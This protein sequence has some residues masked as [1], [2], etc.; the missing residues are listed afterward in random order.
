MNSYYT[1]ISNIDLSGK[2]PENINNIIGLSGNYNS[3]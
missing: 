2:N 3:T 1:N